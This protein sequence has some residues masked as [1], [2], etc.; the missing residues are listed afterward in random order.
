M[1]RCEVS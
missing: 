1:C